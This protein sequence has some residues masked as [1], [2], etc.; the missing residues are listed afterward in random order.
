M[1]CDARE[2]MMQLEMAWDNGI[3]VKNKDWKLKCKVGHKPWD[4]TED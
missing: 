4:E 2:G 1:T 3:T